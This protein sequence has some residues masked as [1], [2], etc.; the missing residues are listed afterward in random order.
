MK[1]TRLTDNN[2]IFGTDQ[3]GVIPIAATRHQTPDGKPI[4]STG[5]QPGPE[6]LERLNAGLPVIVT[7]VGTTIQLTWVD[8][9]FPTDEPA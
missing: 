2:V 6:E 9:G 7:V 5:W 8:V 3:K 4:V 1:P